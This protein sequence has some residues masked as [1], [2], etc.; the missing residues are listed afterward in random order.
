MF[1]I[2]RREREREKKKKIINFLIK[3]KYN[4]KF[5]IMII[6]AYYKWIFEENYAFNIK[7]KYIYIKYKC[8]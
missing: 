6:I 7:K 4:I 1:G 3:L 8:L 2:K 5:V